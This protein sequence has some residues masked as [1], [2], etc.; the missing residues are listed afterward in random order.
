[1]HG[2]VFG[3]HAVVVVPGDVGIGLGLDLDQAVAEVVDELVVGRAVR[4]G[5]AGQVAGRVVVDRAARR[6]VVNGLKAWLMTLA[7]HCFSA[8]VTLSAKHTCPPDH[9]TVGRLIGPRSALPRSIAS[10]CMRYK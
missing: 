10:I 8:S 3:P 6:R 4:R 9:D 5:Q 2:R 1:L 7:S